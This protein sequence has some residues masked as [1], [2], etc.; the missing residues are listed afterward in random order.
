[1]GVVAFIAAR[2]EKANQL[3]EREVSFVFRRMFEVQKDKYFANSQQ[4]IMP[5]EVYLI[6]QYGTVI[7]VE[8]KSWGQGRKQHDT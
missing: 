1:M 8:S 3:V 7:K 2:F 6:W 4:R 5:A